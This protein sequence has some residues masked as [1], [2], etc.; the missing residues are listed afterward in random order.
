M[1]VEVNRRLTILKLLH[2]NRRLKDEDMRRVFAAIKHELATDYEAVD[3][4]Q[5]VVKNLMQ[6]ADAELPQ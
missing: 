3:A 1:W 5:Q 6:N 2:G 4:W